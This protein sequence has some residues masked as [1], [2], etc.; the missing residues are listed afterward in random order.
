MQRPIVRDRSIKRTGRPAKAGR[1]IVERCGARS[2]RESAIC[3][4]L[5]AEYVAVGRTR[6]N[7][8]LLGNG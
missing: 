1:G 7:P 3:G 6:L 4:I 5:A 8:K 2:P